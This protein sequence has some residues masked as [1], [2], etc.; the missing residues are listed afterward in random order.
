MDAASLLPV[1]AL[2]VQEGDEVL[3][4]C[5][6]PGGKSLAITMKLNLWPKATGRL[7]CN[8]VS[9]DRRRRLRQVL[10]TYLPEASVAECIH[11]TGHDCTTW[12]RNEDESFDKSA[13]M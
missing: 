13:Y 11:V 12:K 8:D 1:K 10:E 4:M 5:A 3:D 2:D 7:E 9:N 6:A